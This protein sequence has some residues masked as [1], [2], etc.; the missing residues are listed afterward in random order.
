[1]VS[2][3][4]DFPLAVDE[5]GSNV[6]HVQNL[7]DAGIPLHQQTVLVLYGSE[8]DHIADSVHSAVDDLVVVQGAQF[9]L[10]VVLVGVD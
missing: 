10:A 5:V 2:F 8:I 7:V 3:L 1:M 4:V 6:D 9:F